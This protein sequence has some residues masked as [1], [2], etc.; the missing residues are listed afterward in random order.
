MSFYLYNLF[1]FYMGKSNKIIC[2]LFGSIDVPHPTT[3]NPLYS[4]T[5]KGGVTAKIT[6]DPTFAT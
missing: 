2:H 5:C 4:L 3:T 6:R 1:L